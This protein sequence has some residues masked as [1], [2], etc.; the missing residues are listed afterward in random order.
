MGCGFGF[1]CVM[2]I[3]S[4]VGLLWKWS[5]RFWM[6]CGRGCRMVLKCLLLFVRWGMLRMCCVMLSRCR[7]RLMLSW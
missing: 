6:R 2:M 3:C 7:C 4:F 5:L 1:Y